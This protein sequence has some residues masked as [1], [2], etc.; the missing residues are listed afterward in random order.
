MT[1]I[2][3]PLPVIGDIMIQ[4][5]TEQRFSLR[6]RRWCPCWKRVVMKKGGRKQVTWYRDREHVWLTPH[7]T[8]FDCFPMAAHPNWNGFLFSPSSSTPTHLKLNL[9]CVLLI[10]HSPINSCDHTQTHEKHPTILRLQWWS[11]F[12]SRANKLNNLQHCEPPTYNFN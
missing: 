9:Q 6:R 8:T 7:M 10:P 4:D 5:R 12:S 3:Q 11:L 1:P 2:A